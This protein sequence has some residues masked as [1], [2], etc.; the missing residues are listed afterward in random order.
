MR[1]RGGKGQPVEGREGLEKRS[2]VSSKD[3]E[4]PRVLLRGVVCSA[5]SLMAPG[6]TL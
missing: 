4:V 6:T 3:L 5:V 1:R 2:G